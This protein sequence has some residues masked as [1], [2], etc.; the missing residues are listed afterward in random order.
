MK[1]LL[2]IISFLMFQISNAQIIPIPDANFK[3]FLTYTPQN[4]YGYATNLAGVPIRVDSNFDNQISVQE[5][6]N[7]A[8]L[9]IYDNA[10]VANLSGLEFFINLKYFFINSS[11]LTSFNFPTLI[12]LGELVI[13]IYYYIGPIPYLTSVLNIL[14]LD[15]NTNLI[16]LSAV[17]GNTTQ[18]NLSNNINL[19]YAYL[20]TKKVSNFDLSNN[21]KLKTLSLETGNIANLSFPFNSLLLTDVSLTIQNSDFNVITGNANFKKIEW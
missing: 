10:P 1:K 3:T 4:D 21:S 12:N 16:A 8:G 15:G 13:N 14:N 20:I 9:A 17:T 18:L 2:L 5:A 7:V 6:A 11:I 19:E